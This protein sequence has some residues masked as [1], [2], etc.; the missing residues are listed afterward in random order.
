MIM[1]NVISTVFITACCFF[2]ACKDASKKETTAKENTAN[3]AENV[4]EAIKKEDAAFENE[5][6]SGDS[7]ALAAHYISGALV[8]P[9]NSEPIKETDI[10]G[11]WGSVIRMGVKELK[12]NITDIAGDG[13]VVAETGSYEMFG[14]ENK[15]LDK[16]KYVVVWKKD[17]GNW[18]I[19]RDMFSSN[20]A[21]QGA[22]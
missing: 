19:Y 1:K 13:N 11:F 15:S 9:P 20:L 6:R 21:V 10:A 16:G 2:T 18:K 17:N 8:M 5:V 4:K 7:S 12:I 22:K 3:D 14:A